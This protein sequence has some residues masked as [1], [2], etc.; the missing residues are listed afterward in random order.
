MQALIKLGLLPRRAVRAPSSD[1]PCAGHVLSQPECGTG[2]AAHTCKLMRVMQASHS[3]GSGGFHSCAAAVP[4]GQI[5]AA[6]ATGLPSQPAVSGGLQHSRSKRR[7][8]IRLS[9]LMIECLSQC[10]ADHSRPQADDEGSW[11]SH[12]PIRQWLS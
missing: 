11:V 8:I 6:G 3:A 1:G 2:P 5:P 9:T 7:S 4:G 12:G 10:S